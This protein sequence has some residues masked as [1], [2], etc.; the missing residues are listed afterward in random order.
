VIDI[1]MDEAPP[2]FEVVALRGNHE[3]MMQRFLDD[4]DGRA[5][6]DDE[7][8]R[9]HSRQL[10]RQPPSIFAGTPIHRHAQGLFR[11]QLPLRHKEFLAGL[12]ETHV[13]G[14]YLFVHAGVR[15]GV[16]LPQQRSEDLLWI[17][18]AFLDSKASFGKV[19]VH[20]HSIE[21]EPVVR[22]N[23]IASTPAPTHQPTHLPGAGRHGADVPAYVR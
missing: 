7:W 1:V 16:P 21:R 22:A 14:D 15:P 3:E 5:H 17:R 19:V 23:R 2:G 4:T 20:G 10:R 18:E 13:A 11:T 9:R 12:A 8:R 6:L